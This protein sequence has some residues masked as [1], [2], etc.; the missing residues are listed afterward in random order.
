MSNVYQGNLFRNKIRDLCISAGYTP[1]TEYYVAG[2]KSDFVYSIFSQPRH[3]RIAVEAKAYTGNVG[4]ALVAQ[5]VADYTPALRD[6]SIDEVWVVAENDFSAEARHALELNAGFFPLCYTDFLGTLINFPRY[7]Q[8]LKLEIEQDGILDYYIPQRFA[9]KGSTSAYVDEWLTNPSRSPIAVLST[10]GMGKTSLARVLAYNYVLHSIANPTARIPIYIRLGSLSS[11]QQID[12][13]LGTLF[14]STVPLSGYTFPLFQ[15]MNELG[16]FVILFD[17]LDEMRHAMTWDDFQYNFKQ[18]SQIIF[19][20]T[21]AILFG[22][23]NTFRNQ[24]EYEQIIEGKRYIGKTVITPES[25]IKFEPTEIEPF[26]KEEIYDFLHGFMQMQA[27]K[28]GK[29]ADVSAIDLRIAEIKSLELDELF[30]RPVHSQMIAE[31]ASDFSTPLSKFSRYQLYSEFVRLVTARDFDRGGG[32]GVQPTERRRHLRHLASTVWFDIGINAF[33]PNQVKLVGIQAGVPRDGAERDLLSG[34]LIE[35]KLG[36]VFYFS[37]RSF[38]E[39]LIAE[40]ILLGEFN[41]HQS[42]RINLL[43]DE[44]ID[45]VGESDDLDALSK[46]FNRLAFDTS[47]YRRRAFELSYTIYRRL[48]YKGKLTDGAGDNALHNYCT[49][50]RLFEHR[51]SIRK[52]P[53]RIDLLIN[54]MQVRAKKD[55]RHF[56]FGCQLC[57]DIYSLDASRQWMHYSLTRLVRL[58]LSISPLAEFSK[59]VQ[60]LGSVISVREEDGLGGVIFRRAMLVGRDPETKN[61]FVKLYLDQF[62]EILSTYATSVALRTRPDEPYE[63]VLVA[64]ESVG[65]QNDANLTL[66]RQMVAR[67]GES[68]VLRFVQAVGVERRIP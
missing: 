7:Q 50:L 8:F 65:P 11:Q 43:S 37:H 67:A 40:A 3:K 10:Y 28:K 52:T 36:D 2:K 26:S 23:P 55:I 20:D 9:S 15:K 27:A 47:I 17:G 35:S 62:W 5:V 61:L 41:L 4:K 64:L 31:I 66:I 48:L 63:P 13:L 58:V 24:E 25:S 53:E 38:Q 54:E 34:A 68:G 19:P 22:R 42:D 45:F 44:I 14:T 56:Y 1:L 29:S 49:G 18:I 32:R 60:G 39:F 21:K 46:V 51:S 33:R 57:F 30:S 59:Q 12:G 16:H 6:R